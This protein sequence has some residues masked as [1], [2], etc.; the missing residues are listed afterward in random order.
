MGDSVNFDELQKQRVE[1]DTKELKKLIEAHFEA[2]KKDDEEFAKFEAHV[3]ERKAKRAEQIKE[4]QEKEKL[5][6][7]KEDEERKRKEEEE[8]RRNRD[9]KKKQRNMLG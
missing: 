6:R 9:K 4:R 3:N 1:K 7:A 5:K 8:E 2:R